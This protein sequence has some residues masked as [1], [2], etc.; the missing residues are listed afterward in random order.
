M[1]WFTGGER[2]TTLVPIRQ[3]GRSRG[4]STAASHIRLSRFRP[5][6]RSGPCTPDPAQGRERPALPQARSLRPAPP[7]AGGSRYERVGGHAGP[8]EHPAVVLTCLLLF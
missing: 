2:L 8:V 3:G 1:F 4:R 6:S 7:A 5:R